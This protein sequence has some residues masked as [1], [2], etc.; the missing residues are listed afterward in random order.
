MASGHRTEQR[1]PVTPQA[2]WDTVLQSP[3]RSTLF[4]LSHG[5]SLHL[6]ESPPACTGHPGPGGETTA[7]LEGRGPL[8]ISGLGRSTLYALD[9]L[10]SPARTHAGLCLLFCLLKVPRVPTEGKTP[11]LS[12]AVSRVLLTDLQTDDRVHQQNVQGL[13][14]SH[15]ILATMPPPVSSAQDSLFFL[16]LPA[17]HKQL[18]DTPCLGKCARHAGATS[19]VSGRQR[20]TARKDPS[21]LLSQP[22]I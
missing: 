3:W 11:S 12:S 7:W 4:R 8:T 17:T 19:P 5:G 2:L 10:P 9:V 6:T 15:F 16:C 22:L 21:P 13:H 1:A 20:M 14:C 18:P